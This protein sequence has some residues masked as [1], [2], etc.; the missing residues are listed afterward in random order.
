ML[1][2]D[3]TTNVIRETVREYLMCHLVGKQTRRLGGGM[4]K[5]RSMQRKRLAK[6]K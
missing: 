4:K 2:D 1:P 5:C 6:R 3:W